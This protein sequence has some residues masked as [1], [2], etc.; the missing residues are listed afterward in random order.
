MSVN[1]IDVLTSRVWVGS[2][3]LTLYFHT[4][5]DGVGIDIFVV[6]C[7]CLCCSERSGLNA[8][9]C[10]SVWASATEL[11]SDAVPYRVCDL[12][13]PNLRWVY[14]SLVFLNYFAWWQASCM[15][16]LWWDLPPPPAAAAAG[17]GCGQFSG[18]LLPLFDDW[19][20]MMMAMNRV[21]SHSESIQTRVVVVLPPGRLDV[22]WT[23]VMTVWCVVLLA[24]WTTM[25]VWT[26]IIVHCTQWIFC[27]WYMS[28]VH[29]ATQ[30]LS[31]MWQ[32]AYC[33]LCGKVR[34]IGHN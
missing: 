34:S 26:V 25:I 27:Q 23:V 28:C 3:K 29:W 9:D 19:W 32:H 5:L 15:L 16:S 7:P 31:I 4:F 6:L 18:N 20:M 14:W 30:V 8:S 17:V 12:T 33:V 2:I 24:Q 22:S 13:L 21:M 1:C 11:Y 10:L